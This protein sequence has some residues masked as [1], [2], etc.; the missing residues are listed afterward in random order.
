MNIVLWII[1]GLLA[2]IFAAGGVMKLARTRDQLATSGLAW[3]TDFRPG[4]VR[5]IG[6]LEILAAAGLILPAAL[7]LA[8]ILVPLAAAGL[9]VLMAGAAVLHLRRHEPPAIA[10][11]AL[12]LTLAV[13]VAWG[14]FAA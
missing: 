11:N 13:V 12:F 10:V 7:D 3:A 9:A 5:A 8:P 6:V 4:T 2:A 14:R 1:A